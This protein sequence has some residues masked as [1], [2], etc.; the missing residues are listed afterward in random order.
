MRQYGDEKTESE[1]EQSDKGTMPAL[2]EDHL[3]GED[4]EDPWDKRTWSVGLI[5]HEAL[6]APFCFCFALVLHGKR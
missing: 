6:L 4:G 5:M 1:E 2:Q 3:H